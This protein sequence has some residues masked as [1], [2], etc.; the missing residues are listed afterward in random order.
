MRVLLE[1]SCR[2]RLE[3]PSRTR[4]VFFFFY[5]IARLSLGSLLLCPR[6]PV[7]M[8]SLNVA[9]AVANEGTGASPAHVFTVRSRITINIR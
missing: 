6:V 3:L 2:L 1:K 5:M 9:F 8:T 4:H 7:R